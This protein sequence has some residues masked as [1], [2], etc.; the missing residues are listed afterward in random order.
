MYRNTVGYKI[1]FSF[2]V[3]LVSFHFSHAQIKKTS[4][5]SVLPV[6]EKVVS[7][8]PT[9]FVPIRGEQIPGDPGTVQYLSTAEVPKALETKIIGYSGISSTYWVWETRLLVTDDFEQFKKTYRQYFNDISGGVIRTVDR[10]YI[11]SEKYEAPSEEMR[12]CVNQFSVSGSD[13]SND[14][15]TIDLV[16]ENVMFEWI[17][18]LRVYDKNKMTADQ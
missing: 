5:E 1:S 16:A 13:V 11:S 8:A 6:L 4:V 12:Q 3:F 2:I 14:A 15:L 17:I 10:K 7:A 9:E 18:W